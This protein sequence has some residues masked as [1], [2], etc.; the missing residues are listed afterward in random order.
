MSSVQC[1]PT[2][3]THNLFAFKRWKPHLPGILIA[4]VAAIGITVIFNLTTKGVDVVGMLPQGFPVPS[5]PK[6][7]FSN[8]PLLVGGA[9]G[10]SL[11]AI[12]DTISTS[13]GFAARRGDEVDSNQEMVGIGSA[14]LLAGFF[15]WFPISTSGSRTAVVKQSG[16]KSQLT[17]VVSAILL[18]IMLL[19]FPGLVQ[20]M[21]QSALAAIY[22]IRRPI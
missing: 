6:V 9:L 20:N 13:A 22:R 14:N 5:F 11:I 19:F 16:A 8:L 10:I 21:P 15:Y 7:A 17:G 12:G 18:L 4:V 1:W 2:M 3:F